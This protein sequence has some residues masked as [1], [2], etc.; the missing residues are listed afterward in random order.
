MAFPAETCAP[1]EIQ[2][3]TTAKAASSQRLRVTMLNSDIAGF[4]SLSQEME[5]EEL[6]DFLNNY[7]R[8]M[9]DIVLEHGGNVDKFQGDGILVVFGAP[10]PLDDSA[11]RAVK[12]ARAM[13]RALQDEATQSA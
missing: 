1:L 8:R 4:S 10:E 9:V 11:E 6:V 5:A 2:R 7:F 3:I 12:A 13:V